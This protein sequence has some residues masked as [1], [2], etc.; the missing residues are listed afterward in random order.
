M[1]G[2]SQLKEKHFQANI[3]NLTDGKPVR[4]KKTLKTLTAFLD[5]SD[6]VRVG[7]RID[8][9]T[10]CYDVKHLVLISQDHKKLNHEGTEHVWNTIPE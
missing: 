2:S 1:R 5:E 3:C 4:M 7:R 8:R 9:A 6:I 10:V